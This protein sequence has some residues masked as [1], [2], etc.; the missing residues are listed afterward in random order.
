MTEPVRE[1]LPLLSGGRSLR[2]SGAKVLEAG[3]S[4][5]TV[6]VGVRVATA[7]EGVRSDSETELVSSSGNWRVCR[8]E[9]DVGVG[10][11]KEGLCRI[12]LGGLVA[13]ALKVSVPNGR[14]EVV[15]SGRFLVRVVV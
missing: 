1:A 12:S 6:T 14:S 4:E 15:A 9:L 13:E 10:S 11:D 5:G 8:E 7:S 3:T 2:G